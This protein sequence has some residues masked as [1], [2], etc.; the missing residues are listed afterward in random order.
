MHKIK[1]DGVKLHKIYISKLLKM[2]CNIQTM[3]LAMILETFE[4]NQ[5]FVRTNFVVLTQK[6]LFCYMHTHVNH[7]QR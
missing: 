2:D 4:R 5:F 7:A 3:I 6:Y 1:R